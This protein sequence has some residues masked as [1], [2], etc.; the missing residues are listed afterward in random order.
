MATGNSSFTKVITLTLQD[1][2][3]EIF[4]AVSTNNA[5]L[6]ALKKKGN[7]KVSSG[8]RKFTHPVYY[9]QNTSFKLTQNSKLLILL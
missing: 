7:I 9:K 1:H 8:G 2:G 3:K 6:Y 4:D 5:L